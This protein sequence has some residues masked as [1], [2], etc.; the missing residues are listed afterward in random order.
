MPAYTDLVRALATRRGLNPD[1]SD[2]TERAVINRAQNVLDIVTT[3]LERIATGHP[4][5]PAWVAVLLAATAQHVLN[6]DRPLPRRFHLQRD[7]DVT[8]AS[9]TGRVADG[10][11]FTDGTVAMRWRHRH[12]STVTWAHIDDAIAVHGHDGA[13][14]LIWDD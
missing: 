6:P 8:G 14:R 12:A 5:G 9:G 4:N 11:Q 10:V 2:T 1:G 7:T 13:T 3:D